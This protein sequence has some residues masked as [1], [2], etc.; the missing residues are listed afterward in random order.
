METKSN[1]EKILNSGNFAVTAEIGPPTKADGGII[2]EKA[3]MLKEYIDAFNVTDGQTA[4]V[5]MASW[6]SCLIG[7]EEGLEPIVQMTTRDRNRIALQM[8]V[9]GISALGMKN[10]LCLTGDHISFGNHIQAKGV[11]DID[12]IQF[13]NILKGM[14]D[15]KEF[16]S[17]D[18]MDISPPLFIGASANPFADPFELRVSRLEKKVNAGAD[19]IQT[20]CIFNI[21]KFEEWMKRICDIGLDKKINILGGITPIKSIG[22]AKYMKNKV[23]GMD[24]PDNV[25]DRLSKVPKEK[26][27][28]EGI[29]IAIET[30]EQLKEI[31][32]VSGVHIMAIEWEEIVPEIVESAGLYPRP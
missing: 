11:W 9:L 18:K 19:F 22:A 28:Q 32:G 14:R 29:K 30:I 16:E 4:V 10:V 26:V 5:R 7:M 17:G 21:E 3:K 2:R 8:D 27:S 25:I 1:L 31:E 12:S 13:I 20:Q 23:P 6:A 15:Q 24:V